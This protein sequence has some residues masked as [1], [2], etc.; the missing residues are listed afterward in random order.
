MIMKKIFTILMCICIATNTFAQWAVMPNA[1]SFSQRISEINGNLYIGANDGVYES[2][3]GGN[4]WTHLSSVDAN[5][6]SAYFHITEAGNYWYLGSS[7]Q[8]IYRS[9]DQGQTWQI[10]TAGMNIITSLAQVRD[11]HYDGTMLY[12]IVDVT[13]Y[14]RSDFFYKDPNTSTWMKPT[15]V[16][17]Q[18]QWGPHFKKVVKYNNQLYATTSRGM[19]QSTDGGDTWVPYGGPNGNRGL[20]LIVHNNNM[21]LTTVGVGS[22]NDVHIDK[23]DGTNW[24]DVTPTGF[25][26][27][28]YDKDVIY[29]DGNAIYFSMKKALV[30]DTNYVYK[31][32]DDGASWT[33]LSVDDQNIK[34]ALTSFAVANGELFAVTGVC[35]TGP[36]SQKGVKFG[37]TTGINDNQLNDLI[38]MYPNPANDFV[39]ITNLPIGSTMR[40]LDIT[41]KVVYSSAITNEQTTT[42]N[43]TDFINGIYLIRI[44]NNGNI[45]NRKLV[46]NK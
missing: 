44:E 26:H 4:N 35:G 7:T 41:G 18:D 28:H 16:Q 20:N 8:S 2:T 23:F 43:T 27:G 3:D 21:Y 15:S 14:S 33:M 1:P 9:S 10:D 32:T 17:G 22:A 42:I 31:S 36:T 46:V 37:G 12:A 5:A 13:Q 11:L 24:T 38:K 29:S 30:P 39:T 45:A 34:C 6:S 40:I 25:A 19:F